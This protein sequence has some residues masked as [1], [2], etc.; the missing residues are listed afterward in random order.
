VVHLRKELRDSSP[1]G[2]CGANAIREE[3]QRRRVSPLPSIRTIGRILV[4]RGVLDGRKR[5]RRPPPPPGW[6]LPRVAARKA[7]LESFDFVEGLVIRGGTD[8]M[9]MNGISLHGGLCSSWIESAWTAKKAVSTLISHWSEQGL[10]SYAQFDNDTIFQGAH[11]Y[12]DS[13]GR[14]IRL[15]LQLDITPVFA[16]PRETGFQA[17]IESYN[18]RWQQKVWQR[19]HHDNLATLR[20]HSDRY[21][22]AA[23]KRSAAR[24]D[25]A[26]A[27]RA[28]P[29]DWKLDLQKP[30]K[31][32]VVFLRRTNNLGVV[33]VLGNSYT[34]DPAWPNRLV[35]AE[36]D[37]TRGQIRCYRLRRREPKQQP[38]M[39]TIPYQTPKKRFHE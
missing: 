35:R 37:L 3:L 27:R 14:V 13:F 26:P 8:V 21:V 38:L 17:S 16:P 34:V 6:Y 11:V 20:G 15:C 32:T 36:V 9:V 29:A 25:A 12:P 10:P 24:L 30:L 4:R 2:D 1:L 23:R 5:V 33:E 28:F 22:E 31:G 19:F 7:E 18:G 39:K